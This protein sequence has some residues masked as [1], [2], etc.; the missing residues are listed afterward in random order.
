M[1]FAQKLQ[2]KSSPAVTPED[3]IVKDVTVPTMT[4][5]GDKKPEESGKKVERKRKLLDYG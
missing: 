5:S 1:A 3:K 4:A 2:P